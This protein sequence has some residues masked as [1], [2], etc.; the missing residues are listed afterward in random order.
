MHHQ[1]FQAAAPDILVMCTFYM[2]V[3]KKSLEDMSRFCKYR[4]GA[5][6]NA[7]H[8]SNLYIDVNESEVQ[9]R[10]ITKSI[11]RENV[12]EQIAKEAATSI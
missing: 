3:S 9:N 4:S 11:Y 5:P 6:V 2:S 10:I 1:V 7:F 12:S 8:M